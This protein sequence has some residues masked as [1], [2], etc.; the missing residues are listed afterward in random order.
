[1]R[2]EDLLCLTKED[3]SYMVNLFVNPVFHAPVELSYS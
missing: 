2:L 3:F 1:V